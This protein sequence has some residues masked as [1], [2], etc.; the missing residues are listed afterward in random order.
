M[1][2]TPPMEHTGGSKHSTCRSVCTLTLSGS[3]A[4]RAI[5]ESCAPS[6][7]KMAGTP[8]SP[9]VRTFSGAKRSGLF[10]QYS[11]TSSYC[12]TNCCADLRAERRPES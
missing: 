11:A 5:C 1:L 10:L 9:A 2:S 8:A 3:A 6:R 7:V 12:S 4:T